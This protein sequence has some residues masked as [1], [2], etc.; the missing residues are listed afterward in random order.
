MS[1]KTRWPLQTGVEA[2]SL[3]MVFPVVFCCRGLVLI[4]AA[5]GLVAAQIGAGG[6]DFGGSVDR[7]DRYDDERLDTGIT[8]PDKG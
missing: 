1:D 8:F 4:T 7:V 5:V 3:Y 6:G 2:A